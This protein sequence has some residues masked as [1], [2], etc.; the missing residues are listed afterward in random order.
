MN[1]PSLYRNALGRLFPA[2]T[3]GRMNRLREIKKRP[4]PREAGVVLFLQIFR[5][6]R[7]DFNL[8]AA[9]TAGGFAAAAGFA[10]TARL[11]ATAVTVEQPTQAAKDTAAA[12]LAARIA[13]ASLTTTARLGGTTTA[14]LSSTAGLGA[15]ARLSGAAGLFS[16]TTAGFTTTGLF[17]AAII[18]PVEQVEQAAAMAAARIT[19]T[20]RFTTTTTVAKEGRGGAGAREHRGDAQDQRH[21]SNTNVHRETPKETETGG[22]RTLGAPKVR[23]RRVA[24][25]TRGKCRLAAGRR[26]AALAAHDVGNVMKRYR[27]PSP[28]TFTDRTNLPNRTNLTSIGGGW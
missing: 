27:L 26:I 13:A 10:A 3:F 11:A 16:T 20:S 19:T 2:A 12:G 9:T 8:A 6:E 1:A 15:T 18:V 5:W 28:Q 7:F 23:T 17:A 14:R 24:H 22:K 21:Q 4:L 25:R